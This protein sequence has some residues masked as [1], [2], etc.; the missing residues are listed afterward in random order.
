MQMFKVLLNPTIMG[1]MQIK[2]KQGP[3]QLSLQGY[4]LTTTSQMLLDLQLVS[5]EVKFWMKIFLKTMML[6]IAP[7]PQC[8]VA[9][10]LESKSTK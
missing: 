8:R 10:T 7:T 6:L 2:S 5:L 4:L 9:S 1:S 3:N